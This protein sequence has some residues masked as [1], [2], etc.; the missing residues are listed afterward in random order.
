M[1]YSEMDVSEDFL[2]LRRPGKRWLIVLLVKRG[3]SLTQGA[4]GG[5]CIMIVA[6]PGSFF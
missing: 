1:L 4:F 2:R 3:V 6:L 5:L